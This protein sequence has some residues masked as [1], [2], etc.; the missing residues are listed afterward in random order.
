MDSVF[1]KFLVLGPPLVVAVVLHEVA[2]GYA[3]YKLGDPTAK[4]LGRITLNPIK[5]IDLWMTILLPSMLILAGS[6]VIFGGAKPVPVSAGYFSNPRL[7]MA[8]VAIAGPLTNFA[9]AI[10][11]ALLLRLGFG[12]PT[13]GDTP[14]FVSAIV[15]QWLLYSVI[16]N[17]V[18]GTFN[19]I[20]VPPL[21]GGRIAVGLLP[22]ALALPLARLERYG[23]L[24]IFALLAS[25]Y[26]DRIIGPIL[27]GT[28]KTLFGP[29]G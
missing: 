17:V 9:L 10:L 25:G 2:H 1:L 12:V 8:I 29:L 14:S 4:N 19:L 21:D 13:A 6:P 11:F 23:L 20:P 26:L 22:R 24:I 27:E 16:V 7:G 28:L 3:A 15:T 5:H 18:L